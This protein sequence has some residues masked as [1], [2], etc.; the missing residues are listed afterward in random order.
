MEQRRRTRAGKTGDPREYPANSAIVRHY[1]HVRKSG[2]DPVGNRTRLAYVEGEEETAPHQSDRH[3]SPDTMKCKKQQMNSKVTVTDEM[4]GAAVAERLA[5]SPPFKANRAQSP[6]GPLPDFRTWES[7]RTMTLV[8]GFPRDLPFPPSPSLRRC[9]ILTSITLICS[10]DFDAVLLTD[11]KYDERAGGLPRRGAPGRGPASLR[12]QVGHP[13]PELWRPLAQS[14]PFTV[15]ADNQ[16]AFDIGIFV[17]KTV[18]SSLQNKIDI[19]HVYTEVTFAIGSQFIKH[20]LDDSE[21]IA[22]LQ[23][24]K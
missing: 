1:S 18:E 5:G 17:H 16:C 20:A 2:S 19:Q 9:S 3:D 10:Q 4:A 13:T 24:N 6:A 22:D 8:G 15:T 7:Y 21:Q 12:L 14:S 11:S 23:G